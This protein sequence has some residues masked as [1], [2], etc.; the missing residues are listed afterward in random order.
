MQTH[1]SSEITV[2]RIQPRSVAMIDRQLMTTEVGG[3]GYCD[4]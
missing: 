3:R 1:L 4:R 2:S